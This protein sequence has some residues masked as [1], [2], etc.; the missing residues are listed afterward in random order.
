MTKKC[1]NLWVKADL[2]RRMPRSLAA[3]GW[4]RPKQTPS[5]L[6]NETR[7]PASDKSVIDLTEGGERWANGNLSALSERESSIKKDSALQ[8]NGIPVTLLPDTLT[9]LPLCGATT[10]KAQ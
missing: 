10:G 4:A 5:P 7:N 3:L 6:F 9:I 8:T 2:T 1:M